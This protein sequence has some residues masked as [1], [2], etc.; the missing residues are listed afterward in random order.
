MKLI[1]FSVAA[2]LLITTI[3]AYVIQPPTGMGVRR[4]Y[5]VS[6]DPETVAHLCSKQVECKSRMVPV[7][8]KAVDYD[9]VRRLVT[10]ACPDGKEYKL[11]ALTWKNAGF[12]K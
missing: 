11:S 6:P 4:L 2:M 1:I 9:V 12:E 10:C 5:V 8:A 7:T 3:V